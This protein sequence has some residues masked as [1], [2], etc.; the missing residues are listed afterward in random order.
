MLWGSVMF[1]FLCLLLAC[2]FVGCKDPKP[3][4]VADPVDDLRTRKDGSDWTRFLGPNNDGT[5]SEKGIL[6]KW[7][8]DGL[9]IVWEAEM[10]EGY[11]PPVTSEGR[12]FHF[13]RFKDKQ[14]LTCR[15]AET[16]KLLWKYEYDTT[17]ED[18]YGYSPG[19]RACPVVDAERVYIYGPEGMLEC[20]AAKDGKLI[21]K[22]DTK[23]EYHFHQNFFGVGSVPLIEGDLLIVAIGGSPKGPAPE[24]F[25]KAEG[26]GTG[27]VAFDKKTGKEVWKSSKE[28]AS[29]SSPMIATINEKRVGLYFARGGLVG[30]DP[31][32]GKEKFFHAWRSRI[33]E[34]VN[35]SNPVVVGDTIFLTECYGMGGIMLKLK[36]DKLE[37]VWSDDDKDRREKSMACHW[38]TPIAVGGYLYGSSGRHENEAELRCI[39]AKDGEIKWSERNL[40][41]SQLT[42][43]DGHFLCFTERGELFLLKV[44]PDKFE[45]V[46]LWRT[47]LD[48]PTWAAPVVSHGLVY[49]RGK[50][51]LI[52]AKLIPA[53][54]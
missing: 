38:N 14:R 49:L 2:A 16:G 48:T 6:T 17:Y 41:R 10:G 8:K 11:A 4:P 19:P 45:K 51:R 25:R 42:L 47:D 29:Y 23:K 5:S 36:D 21:W 35:A 50:D 53:K 54:K 40:S 1:R 7:P 26:N 27:L 20:V 34:S 3:A 39:S 28:L 31:K 12:L 33:L 30:F 37:V 18:N 43:I 32:T 13:D 22:V 9:E 15:N 44:N 24:D 52:A 46:A